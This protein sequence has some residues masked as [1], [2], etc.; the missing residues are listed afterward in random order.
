M[1]SKLANRHYNDK[2]FIDYTSD[3]NNLLNNYDKEAK[4][5]KKLESLIDNLN[6]FNKEA[7]KNIIGEIKKN[8]QS[9]GLK[10]ASDKASSNVTNSNL[11]SLLL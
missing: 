8:N 3:F 1:N 2:N 9:K 5:S 10:I 6:K 11:A 4:G 7:L